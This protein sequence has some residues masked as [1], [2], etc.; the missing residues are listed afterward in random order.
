MLELS[1]RVRE[2]GRAREGDGEIVVHFLRK[3][4]RPSVLFL[5]LFSNQYITES[6][7]IWVINISSS[8]KQPY[9][10]RTRASLYALQIKPSA[11][12]ESSSRKCKNQCYW[13]N[14]WDRAEHLVDNFASE[15]SF[16]NR[17]DQS[18]QSPTTNPLSE[19]VFWTSASRLIAKRKWEVQAL[20][21]TWTLISH[22]WGFR[23]SRTIPFLQ[24]YSCPNN[25]CWLRVLLFFQQLHASTRNCYFS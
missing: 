23:N 9:S 15:H 13:N 11:V 10:A 1:V 2:R 21:S 18:V 24:D 25:T 16:R 17:T 12:C 6:E 5:F 8:H 3:R 4:L 20:F 22:L 7:Y 19:F 14:E